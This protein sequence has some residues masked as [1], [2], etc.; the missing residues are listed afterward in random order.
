MRTNFIVNM[1]DLRASVLLE[2]G[3]ERL[4]YFSRKRASAVAKG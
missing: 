3:Q 1:N 2:M 4:K